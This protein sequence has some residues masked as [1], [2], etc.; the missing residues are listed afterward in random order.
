MTYDLE[1]ML[2]SYGDLSHLKTV[3]VHRQRP[4]KHIENL[5]HAVELET[6]L[7]QAL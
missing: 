5:E 2:G 7:F 4:G 3:N 6:T 1:V